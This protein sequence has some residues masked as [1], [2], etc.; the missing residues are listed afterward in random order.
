MELPA[1]TTERLR[2]SV[3]RAEDVEAIIAM[4]SDPDTH[5]FLGPM[6]T[7]AD[8]FSRILRNTGS[9][10]L[11][12]YGLFVVRRRSD[13]TFIGTCGI[14]HSI[15]GLG[16]DFD[17]RA[18]AGWIVA[19]DQT[20]QGHAGEAMRA[21]LDWFDAAF[22]REVMCM[23]SPGNDASTGL[24]VRLGFTHLRDAT[25]PDGD[26]IRLFQRPPPEISQ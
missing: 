15:R 7:R 24:A 8:H 9:W 22:G 19:P 10:L 11:Y 26:P 3:P 17:D 14:F 1:L 25:L 6:G 5:R 23:I 20:G 16:E 13:D 18:E 4:V 2:L 21:A 12:G